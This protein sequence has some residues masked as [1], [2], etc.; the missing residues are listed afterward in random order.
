MITEDD[1]IT[2]YLLTDSL[3]QTAKNTGLNVQTVRRILISC[4][5]Y[6]SE[7]SEIIAALSD[8]GLSV[9]EIAERLKIKPKTVINHMPY[10]RG[11]YSVG[12]KSITALR[13]AYC[14]RKKKLSSVDGE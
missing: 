6:P 11:S 12:E 14:R 9:A 10:T 8:E 5:E 1:V 7:K 4:G 13:I 3:T 2:A